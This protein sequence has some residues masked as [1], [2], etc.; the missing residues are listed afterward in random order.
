MVTTCLGKSLTWNNYIL[1]CRQLVWENH[2]KGTSFPDKET[3]YLGESLQ[4]NKFPDKE[5][6]CLRESIKRINYHPSSPPVI[7]SQMSIISIEGI[8]KCIVYKIRNLVVQNF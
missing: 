8:E 6:A 4:V 3:A 7:Y 1:Q 5:T 2:S